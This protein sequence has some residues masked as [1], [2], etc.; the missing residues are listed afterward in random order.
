MLAVP[1]HRALRLQYATI[2]WNALTVAVSL[3]A[4]AAS[5]SVALT[6]FG[7]DS[8]VEIAAS[9]I[10]VTALRGDPAANQGRYIRLLRVAFVAIGIYLVAQAGY[11]IWRGERP[12][13]SPV[14]I[15]L[16]ALTVVVMTTLAILKRRIGREMGSAVVSTEAK[17]TLID[18]VDSAV[19]LVA[20]LANAT[21]GLWIA[22]PL[23]GLFV[24]A[25]AFHEALEQHG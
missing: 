1:T 13:A 20:L 24:A 12:Q 17:V 22:D 3:P 19:V 10:V 6:G 23:G 25:Y 18:S 8:A 4:A 16:L 9:L 14:G 7:L 5:G 2:G 11:V 15:V 21:L